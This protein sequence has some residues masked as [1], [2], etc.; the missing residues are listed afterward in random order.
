VPAI[1]WNK[2]MSTGVQSLDDE[3]RQVIA[4]LNKLLEA[5]LQGKGHAEIEGLLDKIN[6]YTAIHFRHE[7]ECMARYKCPAA[8]KDAADHARI[9][10]VLAA[11]NAEYERDGATTQLTVRLQTEGIRL[12]VGHIRRIDTQLYP[13]VRALEKTA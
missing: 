11:L 6:R 13:C 5:M 7:E 1:N 12:F 2:S 4:W 8:Q 9:S 3:H 10:K